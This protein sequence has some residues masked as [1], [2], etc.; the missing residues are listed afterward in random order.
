[1]AVNNIE[2]I[3]KLFAQLKKDRKV[4]NWGEFADA[5]GYDRTYISRVINGHETLT[6]DLLKVIN[7][8]TF[9]E[10]KDVVHTTNNVVDESVVKSKDQTIGEL[11]AHIETLK[12][13][14]Q[15]LK[16]QCANLGALRKYAQGAHA[17]LLTLLECQKLLR[18]QALKM[19]IDKDP[20]FER[21]SEEVDTQYDEN[22]QHTLENDN[23]GF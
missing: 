15:L 3:K 21:A 7:N 16:A 10:T 20:I 9:G 23:L 8:T 5:V 2:G 13:Q 1:M 12:E 11:K 6:A 14:V 4:L 19:K 17:R 22:L 18:A